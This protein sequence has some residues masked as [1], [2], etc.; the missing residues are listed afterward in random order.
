MFLNLN[1]LTM[2]QDFNFEDFVTFGEDDLNLFTPTNKQEDEKVEES[3]EVPEKESEDDNSGQSPDDSQSTPNSNDEESGEATDNGEFGDLTAQFNFWKES[4]LLY[5]PEDYQFDNTPEGLEKAINTSKENVRLAGAQAIYDELPDQF[6]V[7]LD[8]ALNGGNDVK[9]V[10]QFIEGKQSVGI[11]FEKPD[12]D[13]DSFC[14][15][16]IATYLRKTTKL[17]DERI[18][19][20]IQAYTDSG[21]LGD[22]SEAIFDDLKKIVEDEEAEIVKKAQRERE[23]YAKQLEQSYNQFKSALEKDSGIPDRKKQEII[24]AVWAAGEFEGKTTSKMAYIQSKILSNPEHLVQ[25]VNM[26]L[27]YDPEKGFN[28]EKKQKR[29][30]TQQNLNFRERLMKATTGMTRP[31]MKGSSA[32]G[33]ASG[34]LEDF[35]KYS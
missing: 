19:K 32:Q 5:L 3:T 1:G 7:V 4:G 15:R 28:G 13:D 18:Q 35:L 9:E 34:S 17:S 29:E 20:T 24:N 14:Q 6:K 25:Y 31:G 16:V 33:K 21:A 22:Q 8:Y 23:D 11:D 12:F 2:S 10:L 26:L 30:D 27:D